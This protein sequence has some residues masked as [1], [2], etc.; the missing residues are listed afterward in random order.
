MDRR[1][2]Q[3]DWDAAVEQFSLLF[4]F[5]CSS[6]WQ[7]RS[8]EQPEP[9]PD[10]GTDQQN[11]RSTAELEHH[12]TAGHVCLRGDLPNICCLLKQRFNRR[13][14]SRHCQSAVDMNPEW[15]DWPT[16]CH[17][18][19]LWPSYIHNVTRSEQKL[20]H[21]A[22]RGETSETWTWVE[23]K[24]DSEES[25]K[26][27]GSVP[28]SCLDPLESNL[29]FSHMSIFSQS[30]EWAARAA[31]NGVEKGATF[32]LV[33]RCLNHTASSRKSFNG[34]HKGQVHSK[35]HK[36]S[37][38]FWGRSIPGHHPRALKWQPACMWQGNN[39]LCHC[40]VGQTRTH[41]SVIYFP[42]VSPW[43]PSSRSPLCEKAQ[44]IAV[45]PKF[46]Q[47]LNKQYLEFVSLPLTTSD[48]VPL[49]TTVVGSNSALYLF[50]LSK[51]ASQQERFALKKKGPLSDLSVQM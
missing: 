37:K 24:S 47:W 12:S 9:A 30:A 1:C 48:L 35:K 8:R 31:P 6:F 42:A 28:T 33:F 29:G 49:S 50:F 45:F 43:S 17:C 51:V 40:F 3:P 34:V 19:V 10:R 38:K 41:F 44:L 27:H 36:P 20:Y 39:E 18:F 11:R 22:C 26:A 16:R 14:A 15:P 32:L 4:F 21:S 2:T 46:A 5:G 13:Q 25:D 23:C 7:K